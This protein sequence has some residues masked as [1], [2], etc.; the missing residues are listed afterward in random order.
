M[1]AHSAAP[2]GSASAVSGTRRGDSSLARA[3]QVQ[4]EEESPNTFDQRLAVAKELQGGGL[5]VI[6]DGDGP[7]FASVARSVAHRSPS[8]QMVVATDDPSWR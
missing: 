4:R 8:G 3:L 1:I 7:V 6:I 5:V 2:G